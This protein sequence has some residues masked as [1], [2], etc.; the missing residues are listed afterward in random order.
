MWEAPTVSA[1]ILCELHKSRL[2]VFPNLNSLPSHFTAYSLGLTDKA[3]G[4]KRK[5][6]HLSYPPGAM[7]EINTGILE[8]Y[9]AIQCRGI[10][11]AIQAV[12]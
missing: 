2:E 6:H 12:Q 7:S 10:E 3:D 9:G 5:I 8:H 11:D 4:S 1:D